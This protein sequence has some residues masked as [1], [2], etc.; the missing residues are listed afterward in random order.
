ML[1]DFFAG[2]RIRHCGQ[3]GETIVEVVPYRPE[4]YGG[5]FLSAYS[6]SA[7]G[8]GVGGRALY[9]HY[10]IAGVHMQ[11]FAGDAA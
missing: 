11:Y 1:K 8:R 6:V 4:L 9:P 10:V 7:L 3:R 2:E 5:V